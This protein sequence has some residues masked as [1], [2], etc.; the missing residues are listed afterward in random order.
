MTG[1]C[2]GRKF[3]RL[4]ECTQCEFREYCRTASDPPLL[5]HINADD[6]PLKAKSASDPEE[7]DSGE[8]RYTSSQMVEVIRLLIELSDDRI[9][10]II[11]LKL[12]DPDISLADIGRKFNISKQAVDKEIKLAIEFCPALAVVLTNR[13]MYNKWRNHTL[14]FRKGKEIRRRK[15]KSLQDLFQEQLT[16]LFE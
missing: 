2:Y 10:E 14:P 4:E 3:D 6:L 12:S 11:R 7:D 13:P 5:S 1:D 8:L 9:R 16:F 15:H